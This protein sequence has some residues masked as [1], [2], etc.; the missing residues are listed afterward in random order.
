MKC[1]SWV[2]L[3]VRTLANPCFGCKPKVRV[4]INIV[5][6]KDFN[7]VSRGSF[8]CVYTQTLNK[9]LAKSLLTLNYHNICATIFHNILPKL[10]SFYFSKTKFDAIW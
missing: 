9:I 10:S 4:T 7:L 6:G 8:Y 3:L 1:G 2:S 5:L